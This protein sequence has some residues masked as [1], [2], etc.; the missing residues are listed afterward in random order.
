MLE[1]VFV[2]YTDHLWHCLQ[3]NAYQVDSYFKTNKQKLHNN[4]N[5]SKKRELQN[6]IRFF[7]LPIINMS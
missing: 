4:D 2:W 3:I 7:L 1:L 6:K 5:N